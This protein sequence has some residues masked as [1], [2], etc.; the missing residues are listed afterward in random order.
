MSYLVHARRWIAEATSTD[1]SAPDPLEAAGIA[2]V[3]E[4]I[5]AALIESARFGEVWIAL[6]EAMAVELRTE[7]QS[8]DTPR[9]VLLAAD[10]ARLRGKSDAAVRAA[11]RAAAVI[12]GARVVQ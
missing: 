12:P 8:S 5:G 6:T 11:L 4:Q 7:E 1:G 2:D 9:P 10:V 3:R